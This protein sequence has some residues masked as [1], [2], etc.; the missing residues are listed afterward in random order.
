MVT[1][2]FY[3]WCTHGAQ[4]SFIEHTR[5]GR[6]IYK[7]RRIPSPRTEGNETLL[8]QEISPRTWN[9]LYSRAL[10]PEM[11]VIGKGNDGALQGFETR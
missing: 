4:Y 2:L 11:L 10:A 5:T 6:A 1:Y 3:S 9:G 8:R 7:L